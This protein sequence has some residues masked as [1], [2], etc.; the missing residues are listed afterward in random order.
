[1]FGMMS[2]GS[3]ADA[4]SPAGEGKF[5]SFYLADDEYGVER[6][7]V[8]EVIGM[9]PIT[10]VPRTPEFVRGVINFRGR[11]IPILDLRAKLGV[12]G[13]HPQSACIIVVKVRSRLTGII[14][15]RVSDAPAGNGRLLL[16]IECLLAPPEIVTI[17]SL[18]DA[19]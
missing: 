4:V 3:I 18:R 19:A 1:V 12:P 2:D 10:R 6:G 5:L 8:H 11:V 16:D 13:D 7:K 9:L 17:E 14:V 15:D